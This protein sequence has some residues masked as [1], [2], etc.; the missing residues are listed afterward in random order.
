[1]ETSSKAAAYAFKVVDGLRSYIEVS[2][3]NGLWQWRNFGGAI[4]GDYSSVSLKQ[5]S[6]VM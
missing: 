3:S 2:I 5:V 6:H 4:S 1:M